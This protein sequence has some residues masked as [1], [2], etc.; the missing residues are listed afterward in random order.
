MSRRKKSKAKIDLG[1]FVNAS[2]GKEDPIVIGKSA[3]PRCFKSLKNNSRPYSCH[4]FASKK[5]WMT[6]KIFEGIFVQLVKRMK[7]ENRNIILFLDNAPCHP[8][9]PSS[10]FTNIKL[11]F[12]PKKTTSRSQPLDAGIIKQWKVKAKRILLRYVCSKVD[13]K[14]TASEIT[15]SIHLLMSIQ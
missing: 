6:S 10:S 15:K 3:K 1:I 8:P 13:G 5:A 7:R 9:L 14:A 11:A 12:L 2:G 4:Y